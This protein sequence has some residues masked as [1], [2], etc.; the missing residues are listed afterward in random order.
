MNE[1]DREEF[2]EDDGCPCGGIGCDECEDPCDR[3]E[4][5]FAR[6]ICRECETWGEFQ[7]RSH[8]DA[9]I[10]GLRFHEL[11]TRLVME[12]RRGKRTKRTR[13]ARFRLHAMR[14]S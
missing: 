6:G 1:F 8:G 10:E 3:E 11:I 5:D 9:Y 14:A 2:Y 7:C 12:A 13:K 4:L